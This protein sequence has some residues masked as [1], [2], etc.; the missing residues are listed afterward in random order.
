MLRT[1]TG[2]TAC[3]L[4]AL[5]VPTSASSARASSN[6]SSQPPGQLVWAPCEDD[7]EPD[8]ECAFIAVPLDH[9]NPVGETIDLALIRYPA[10]PVIREGAVL[11]NPGGPG[12]SGYDFAAAAGVRLAQE[13]GLDGRFD[14]VGFDPRGVDRSG[15][16]ECVTD[17]EIDQGIYLDDTPDNPTEAI[18][19]TVQE[20]VF[21][22]S[23]RE[24]YGDT[25]RHYSTENTARDM[26]LIRAAHGDEQISYLGISYGSYLGAVY[27][28]LFPERVRAMVLD[29]A[30]EY[31]NDSEYVQWAAQLVAF[32][33]SFAN[34]VAW[35]EQSSE[36]AFTAVDVGAR[37]DALLTGI[38]AHP[39]K[40]DDG[41]PVNQVVMEQATVAAMYSDFRW[42]LLASA[43]VE[44]EAGDGTRLLALADDFVGRSDDGTYDSLVQANPVIRCA[45]GIDPAPPA[46]PDALLARI[47]EDAP[48]FGR[49][50][51]LFDLRDSCREFIPHDVEPIAP[52]YNGPAPIIV[53]GGL[54]DP[55]TP[56]QWAEELT[57][58]MGPSAALVTANAEGHGQVLANSCVTGI[59][60]AALRDL[61]LPPPGVV[62]EADPD[63]PRPSFWD[64]IP[65]PEG[66]GPIVDD[67]AV[68]L[69][70]GLLPTRFYA[71]VW[72]LTGDAAQVTAAYEAE[73][74]RL[75]FEV[76]AGNEI[77]A[78]VTTLVVLA[79]D[80]TQVVVLVIPP[81][82][83]DLEP[84]LEELAE[85]A[86]AGQGFVAVV[87]F[88]DS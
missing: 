41:R 53:V 44:A 14:I 56:F 33:D 84:D 63:V 65:V 47:H 13:M 8:Y 4:A 34:W 26:D 71:D 7:V 81:T 82:A 54:H 80:G 32:E 51:T 76:V 85:L 42:P 35:C 69:A 1:L 3:L 37:W 87:A 2:G 15:A 31:T 5:L 24:R 83:F 58:L 30:A 40:S 55:A 16:I 86:P 23:C 28:T 25:L 36:C 74:A 49:S 43:L 72:Y 79:P 19:F 29:S 9:A 18:V 61:Q 10:E 64:Q 38:D 17:A 52:A 48:R 59:E 66:V 39:V 70:L 6:A 12:G 68:E 78:G 27:A 50:Y 73:F 62:C 88:G 20:L 57:A 75:G 77:L 46:D 60:A 22:A 21:P 45:S 11:L 67:P